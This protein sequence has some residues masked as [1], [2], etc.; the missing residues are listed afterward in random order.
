MASSIMLT[1]YVFTTRGYSV[2]LVNLVRRPFPATLSHIE[3]LALK[4][5]RQPDP[6]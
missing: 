2:L 5:Y 1:W 4:I 6:D 3:F